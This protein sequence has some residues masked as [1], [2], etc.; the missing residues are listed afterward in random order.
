[1]QLI[2]IISISDGNE[3]DLDLTIQSV[4]NQKFNQYKHIVIAKN[5]PIILFKIINQKK[6]HL[7][8]EKISLDIMP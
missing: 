5:Y 4:K 2:N 3:K 6:F 7:L 1:M 8:L